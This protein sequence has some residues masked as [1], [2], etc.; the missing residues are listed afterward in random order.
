LPMSNA[1]PRPTTSSGRRFST[2]NMSPNSEH[3]NPE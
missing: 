1:N 2:S 3:A